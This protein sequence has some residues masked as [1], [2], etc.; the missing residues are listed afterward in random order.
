MSP[1]LKDSS[2]EAVLAAADIVDVVSGYT[3]LRKRG[4][5]YHG[6]CPFHQEKTPS[7][8]VSAAKGLY[9]CFGC[10]E[11]GDV[12]R[13]VE[14]AENLS[15]TEAVEQLAQRYA[16]TLEYEEGT[17]PDAGRR[18]RDERLLQLLDKAA[19]F[20]ERYLWETDS[21]RVARDYLARRGLNEQSCRLF[22]V[23]LAPAEW[24][25]LYRRAAKEGFSDT[26]LEQA[27]LLVRRP[28]KVYDR[29]RDRLMFPLVDHRGRVLGFG[30]RTL[31]DDTPKYVNSPEGPLYQKGRLLYGLFQARKAIA[32]RDEV[33]V[34]EGYTDVI[35]LVQTGVPNVV[36]SMGTALTDA[37]LGLMTRVTSN[38][39]FMFDADRAGMEAVLRLDELARERSLRPMVALLP[40][41]RDPADV[42]VQDGVDAVARVMA[43]KVSL[44]EFQ[45]RRALSHEDV[46]T[47][48]GRVRAF[49]AVRSLLAR[50]SSPKER[51]EQMALVADRLRLSPE[52]VSLLLQER[53]VA[54]PL[55]GRRADAS[56]A[57]RRRGEPGRG[58]RKAGNARVPLGA[59]LLGAEAGVER[60]FLVAAVHNPALALTLLDALTPEHFTDP[61]NREVF[62]GVLEAFRVA[63]DSKDERGALTLHLKSR[64]RGDSEAGRVFVRLLMESDQE[65]FGP[66]VLQELHLRL[67]EQHLMRSINR[68]RAQIE[69]GGQTEADE[70]HLYHL[71]R[72]LQTVRVN[73]TNLDP[74]MGQT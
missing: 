61:A 30:G 32:E 60:D 20:Y 39:T 22:R 18:E 17:G 36:A 69:E 14:R 33:V 28:G 55:R 10:G 2:L 72:L 12:V 5:D 29:F 1:R 25:G 52:N 56:A 57:T 40:R 49:E 66:A 16:V 13:F 67:Q 31:T 7:F 48:E 70:R 73:L 53:P 41:D 24:Q 58:V 26:E 19:R 42:A 3:S 51:E 27:G 6:L 62:I 71:E 37:Q 9:Y 45:L 8:S 59:R 47:A 43:D 63:A 74:E 50:A 21:G 35:A 4:A 15:F 34:V 46:A 11:G 65:R 38:V 68:L 64:A 23:G 44:L 54:S